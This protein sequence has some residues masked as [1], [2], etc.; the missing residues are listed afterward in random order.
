MN[1]TFLNDLLFNYGTWH[2]LERAL[3]RFLSHIGRKDVLIVGGSNDKGA[4]IVATDKSGK[5]IVLQS[6]YKSTGKVGLNGIKEAFDSRTHYGAEVI[7]AAT[8]RSFSNEAIKFCEE[9][10]KLNY[11]ISLIDSIWLKNFATDD[12]KFPIDSKNKYPLRDYQKAALDEIKNSY[13]SGNQKALIT[14]A[15]GLGKT[16]VFSEFISYFLENNPAKKVLV[17]AHQ[18]EIVKQLEIS[19]WGRLNK[20]ISTYLWTSEDEPPHDYNGVT[21]ATWQSVVNACDAGTFSSGFDLVV[22]DEAHHAPSI[23]YRRL[24]DILAPEFT[25]GVTATPWRDDGESLRPLFG[26]P[27]YSMSVVDGM[28][29]GWLSNVNYKMFTDGMDW[30]FVEA[31]SLHGKKLKD[32][33][34]SLVIPERDNA[35]IKSI[36]SHYKN[37]K[38]PRMII[39][40]N[41]IAHIEKIQKSLLSYDIRSVLLHNELHRSIKYKNLTDFKKGTLNI[42]LAVN[43]LNEGIDIPDVNIIVF[44]K[45]THQR[46]IFLQQLGRGLRLKPDGGD[47]LVLDY[48]ADIRRIAEGLSLNKEAKA[49]SNELEVVRYKKNV[50]N[51]E[52]NNADFFKEYLEDMA[53]SIS[54]LDESSKLEFPDC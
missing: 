2:S 49:K 50:V 27:V 47:V 44:C 10:K 13:H 18:K 41:S 32:L 7:I 36:I 15:T 20:Y 8:N 6:K 43:M 9:K 1:A 31:K 26:D 33:N 42:I 11:R 5:V 12:Q 24:L 37:H 28:N 16:S 4:D 51:F 54:N 35:M 21:F 52:T 34:K 40:G 38:N 30:D 45:V 29:K 19:A 46:K 53:E 23:N 48:V 39:F 22:V 17:L 25:L 14:L 3:A